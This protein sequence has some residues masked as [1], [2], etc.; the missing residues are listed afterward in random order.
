MV[1]VFSIYSIHC[2]TVTCATVILIVLNKIKL[3]IIR[4]NYHL[5]CS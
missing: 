3:N 4:Q 5:A 1:E 2:E